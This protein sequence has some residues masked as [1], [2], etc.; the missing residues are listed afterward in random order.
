MG[1]LGTK[2]IKQIYLLN[3]FKQMQTQQLLELLIFHGITFLI[4]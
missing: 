1:L 2:A 4:G 3:W